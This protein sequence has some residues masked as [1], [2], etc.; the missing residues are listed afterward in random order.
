MEGSL[1]MCYHSGGDPKKQTQKVVTKISTNDADKS[2]HLDFMIN[3]V[4]H[5]FSLYEN[6]VGILKEGKDGEE[7]ILFHLSNDEA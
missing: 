2:F 6:H 5:T 3:G 4:V 1:F 7:E